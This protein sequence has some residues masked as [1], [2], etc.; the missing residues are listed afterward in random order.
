MKIVRTQRGEIIEAAANAG[1]ELSSSELIPL[2]A[3]EAAG[4][5]LLQA[6]D[7]EYDRLIAEL[8]E[9]KKVYPEEATIFTEQ[10]R[11]YRDEQKE[12]RKTKLISTQKVST[13]ARY[14]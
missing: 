3:Q 12:I 13:Y 6:R 14:I 11:K 2:I 5:E 7:V 9:K 10:I 4:V 8:E 1:A